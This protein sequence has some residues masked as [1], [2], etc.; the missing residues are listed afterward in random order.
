MSIDEKMKKLILIALAL[1]AGASAYASDP[2]L[3]IY[4]SKWIDLGGYEM[5][6]R[7]ESA[8]AECY[9]KQCFGDTDSYACKAASH[10]KE[11]LK[12]YLELIN[13]QLKTREESGYDQRADLREQIRKEV[14]QMNKEK[15]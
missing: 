15:N 12:K 11:M 4:C 9:E 13:R 3:Q 5:D 7:C 1:I 2:C 14:E 6:I 10:H 8:K